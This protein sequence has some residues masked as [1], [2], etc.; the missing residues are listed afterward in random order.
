MHVEQAYVAHPVPVV[1]RSASG[2]DEVTQG[3]LGTSTSMN[4]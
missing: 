1:G 2:G 4:L 3:S